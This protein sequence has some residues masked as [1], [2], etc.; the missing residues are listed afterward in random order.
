MTSMKDGSP[1]PLRDP[2]N[3]KWSIL[4]PNIG[5]K[6]IMP[7]L[8]LT[9]IVAGIGA[10]VISN[11]V[12]S[13]LQ[14]RFNN[15]L[16]D[17]GRRVAEST[18]QYEANRLQVLRAVV[19]TVGVAQALADE[20]AA[21][22]A[23]FVPQIIANSDS[24]A[25][26]LLN[27][28]GVEV[29]G[30][31]Q[32]PNLDTAVPPE[33]AG[34]DLSDDPAVRR[35]LAGEIDQFGDKRITL[36]ET[37]G[38]LVLYTV[39]PVIIGDDQVGVVMIGDELRQM[40]EDLT[41][42]AVARVTLYDKTGQVLETTLGGIQNEETAVELAQL[43]E[44]PAKYEEVVTSATLQAPQTPVRD[45]R[46]LQ[47]DYLLAYGDWRLRGQSFGM[48]SV[49][50]SSNFIL[51]TL[52]TSRT[53]FS[54]IFAGATMAVLAVGFITA[55]Q[56]TKPVD[57]LVE[58][59]LAVTAGDLERRSNIQ[60]RDEIGKLAQTFDIMTATLAQSN[61][62]LTEQASKLK[63]IL[64]SIVD[65]VIVMDMDEQII[66]TNAAA[67]QLLL[68]MS[69]DFNT[70]P[71]RELSL[72]SSS[73]DTAESPPALNAEYESKRFQVGNR[74]LSALAAPVNTP[75]GEQIGTV[76]VMR[77]ITSEA[78][79]DQLKD[80]FITSISHELRTPLTVIKVYTDLI[81]RTANG[82]LDERQIGFLDKISKNSLHLE[83]HINQLINISEIQAGTFNIEKKKVD[84]VAL[85]QNVTDNWEERITSKGLA[86]EV[87]LPEQPLWIDADPNQLSWATEVLLSNAH[88]YTEEGSITVTVFAEESE[89]RLAVEDTGIGIAAA[90]QPHLFDRFFRASNALN[91]NV[92]G[93]GLGLY[94]AR[95]IVELL[96]G[97]I[98]VESESGSGSTFT[99]ALPLLETSN[100]PT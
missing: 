59:A 54:L 41:I 46:F 42:A 20:N 51:S 13:S 40:T 64:N 24:H 49:A 92:R 94:I 16:L 18:V 98:W 22:L 63:A 68:D 48:F 57:K 45:V 38:K 58:T 33:S 50:L 80:A 32:L 55:Q 28:D 39:G 34:A 7:Y 30:W 8:L 85:I 75:D 31:Q 53:Q 93:V 19:G 14:E 76:I 17:A 29:F 69:H 21:A 67:D 79:A 5:F 97:R 3:K 89:A 27:M 65:G 2:G 9:L 66:T 84:F 43:T 4:E 90:D 10:F 72:L 95:S 61:Q 35:V 96:N 86:F 12:A 56:I 23:R 26:K 15:Q 81:Q 1:L 74:I 36:Y 6:I 37:N 99:L 77:D 60:S 11:L 87:N 91:F 100:E 78:E 44:T 71:M 73:S 70:G 47:Q 88:N 82:H 83:Q 62:E 25:V 52:A